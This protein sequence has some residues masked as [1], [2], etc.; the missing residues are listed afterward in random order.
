MDLFS[1]LI[2]QIGDYIKISSWVFS[3]AYLWMLHGSLFQKVSNL[4]GD[5]C[6]VPAGGGIFRKKKLVYTKL[7]L[8][9]L[10]WLHGAALSVHKEANSFTQLPH[11]LFWFGGLLLCHVAFWQSG[12]KVS[13]YFPVIIFLK[14]A[15]IINIFKCHILLQWSNSPQF[16]E[17]TYVN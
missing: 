12:Q 5:L 11:A 6:C 16:Y 8:A 2:R 7:S 3:W 13:V 14:S 4:A 15:N 9:L 17:A 10:L 1:L